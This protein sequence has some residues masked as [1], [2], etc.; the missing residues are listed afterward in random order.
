MTKTIREA[1]IDIQNE[2]IKDPFGWLTPV[3]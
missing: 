1:L 3:E 2:N